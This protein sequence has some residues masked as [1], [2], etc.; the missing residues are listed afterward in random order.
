MSI[1]IPL[2]RPVYLAYMDDSG[3][4]NAASPYQVVASIVI[5]DREFINVES[6]CGMVIENLVE[7][8]EEREAFGEFHACELYWGTG[9]F[10]HLKDDEEKRHKAIF[11]LLIVLAGHQYPI[12]YG[13]VDK[14]AL[15]AT[16]FS[17]AN[18]VDIAFRIC[19]E[20][21]EK[22]MQACSETSGKDERCIV[23]MDDTDDKRT[24][25]ELRR[26]FRQ[27]RRQ[28][29]PPTGAIG[30]LA[31]LHEDMYFGDSRE[32]IGIQLADLC[33]FIIACHLRG[34]PKTE[35]CYDLFKNKIGRAHV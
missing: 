27:L 7:T 34:V 12:I 14:Q 29:R 10:K 18:P 26:S 35:K 32:S 21:V 17:S 6:V 31:H 25:Q 3:T 28:Q 5:P 24:K 9:P 8:R 11:Q 16:R 1:G 30:K 15:Y 19:A 23:V 13:A 20:G 22:Y 33:A 2:E 4:K